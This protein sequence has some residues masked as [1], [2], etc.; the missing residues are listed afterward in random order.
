V[1][2]EGIT[3][4]RPQSVGRPFFREGRR[5][6]R[7]GERLGSELIS[8]CH[9][10]SRCLRVSCPPFGVSLAMMVAAISC[11]N[12]PSRIF[13]PR[14]PSF[15]FLFVLTPL[16]FLSFF[17]PFLRR[18]LT[19]FGEC[20]KLAFDSSFPLTV[21]GWWPAFFFFPLRSASF[22]PLCLHYFV[23]VISVPSAATPAL[24]FRPPP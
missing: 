21:P 6:L 11:H 2:G 7:V 19:R 3:L 10:S 12:P 20:P 18:F 14:L 17:F 13:S 15:S 16:S 24:L 1:T 23:E 8:R 9:L 4:C 22:F 5:V